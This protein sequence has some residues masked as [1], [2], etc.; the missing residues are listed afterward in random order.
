MSLKDNFK[1]ISYIA[2]VCRTENTQSELSSM[3]AE[4]DSTIADM[5]CEVYGIDEYENM[6]NEND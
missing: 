4:L 5:I 6:E 1:R 3:L 2:N